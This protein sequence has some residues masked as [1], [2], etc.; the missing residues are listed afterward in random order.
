MFKLKGTKRR[1]NITVNIDAYAAMGKRSDTSKDAIGISAMVRSM[2]GCQH[3][4]ERAEAAC[5]GVHIAK[6]DT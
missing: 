2:R 6:F 3:A 4:Q 5:D 1:N